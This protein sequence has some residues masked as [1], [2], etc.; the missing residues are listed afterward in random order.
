MDTVMLA[1]FAEQEEL[2]SLRRHRSNL[3]NT[4]D[5]MELPDAEF[6]K[7]FRLN[8]EA[9]LYILGE[10]TDEFPPQRQGALSVKE[11]LA[12]CLRF[13]AEGSYQ[14]GTGKDF[15]VAVAQPTFSKILSEILTVFERK[16]CPQWINIRMSNEEM[17]RA[18][19]FFYEKSGIPGVIM[20]VDGTH[21][22]II[23]PN[24]NRNLFY[25]RKGF[26]SLNVMIMCDDTQRIRFVDAGYQGSNHDSHVWGLSSARRYMQQLHRN[27]DT[28]I[29]I[30]GDAGYPSEPWLITPHRAPEDGSPESNFNRL[31]SVGRGIIERTIG[32]LKNR[33]RCILGARQL[34]YS[35]SKSSKIINVC[36]A[37]HNLCLTYLNDDLQ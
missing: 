7:N 1:V 13:F 11:K 20:C 33:F 27:G 17:R 2:R 32:V 37:L 5:I 30:L 6:I 24:V 10:I 15:D 31:H 19:R 35:P 8:K 36:C 18:K 22:K 9:F 16:M 21:I 12:A 4:T 28:N 29:K 34:H 25:N 14:H 26:Y 3:R 23:P